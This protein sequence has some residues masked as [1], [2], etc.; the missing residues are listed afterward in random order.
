M[1]DGGTHRNDRSVALVTGGNR[2]IGREV[3]RQLSRQ[4]FRTILTARDEKQGRGPAGELG[5]ELVRLDV[6]D[7]ASADRCFRL[8]D[9]QYGR[10]DVLSTTPPFTMTR[11]SGGSTPTLPSWERPSRRT[12][13]EP[14][15]AAAAPS[16]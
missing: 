7:D 8:V 1:V 11:G 3:V 15:A 2:G 14:G 10:L 12:C 16:R 9:E 6:S 13:S 5:T 4:G